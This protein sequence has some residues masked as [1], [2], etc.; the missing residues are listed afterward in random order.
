MKF[1]IY[2]AESNKVDQME[3]SDLEQGA[4]EIAKTINTVRDGSVDYYACVEADAKHTLALMSEDLQI[5]ELELTP[6]TLGIWS[7]RLQHV[8]ELL[9]ENCKLANRSNATSA[10]N[11]TLAMSLMSSHTD[12]D[13]YSYLGTQVNALHQGEATAVRYSFLNDLRNFYAFED[14]WTK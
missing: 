2:I 8:H 3:S 13:S 11:H 10:R 14:V 7:N 4:I 12:F 9:H 1:L 6:S 5:A